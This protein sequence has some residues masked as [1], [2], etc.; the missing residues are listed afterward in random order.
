MTQHQ[1]VLSRIYA[2]ILSQV[3]LESTLET[4][5]YTLGERDYSKSHNARHFWEKSG[6]RI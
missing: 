1:Q 5:I 4:L 3:K 2:D 6:H